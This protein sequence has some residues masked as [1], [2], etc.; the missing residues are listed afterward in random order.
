MGEKEYDKLRSEEKREEKRMEDL[1]KV[2]IMRRKKERCK[3]RN[4]ELHEHKDAAEN[5]KAKRRKLNED[6][7]YKMVVQ[8]EKLE[9]EP[10]MRNVEEKA[11]KRRR[12][13]QQ[14][15]RKFLGGELREMELEEE[16]DWKKRREEIL[17]RLNN[18]EKERLERIEMAKAA[19]KLGDAQRV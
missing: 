7:E 13:V 18:E 15:S 4:R 14:E 3:R 10:E 19:E 2:E 6:G 9:R 17:E 8:K 11:Y 12:I 16:V 5:I 1:M